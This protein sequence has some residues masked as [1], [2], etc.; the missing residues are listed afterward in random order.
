MN[1]NHTEATLIGIGSAG[2]ESCNKIYFVAKLC[3]VQLK[4]CF[5]PKGGSIC[6]IAFWCAFDCI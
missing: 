2:H 3:L 1:C 4:F 5:P 6:I